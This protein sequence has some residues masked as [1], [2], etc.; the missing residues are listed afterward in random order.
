MKAAGRVAGKRLRPCW[1]SLEWWQAALGEAGVTEALQGCK[2]CAQWPWIVN[3]PNPCCYLCQ[4][5][6]EVMEERELAALAAHQ[7]RV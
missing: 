5:I 7:V 1:F 2:P 4:A 3:P 6:M